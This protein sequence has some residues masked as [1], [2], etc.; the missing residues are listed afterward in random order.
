M[1]PVIRNEGNF[2]TVTVNGQVYSF[3]PLDDD[4]EYSENMIAAWTAWRDFVKEGW[5]SGIVPD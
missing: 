5:T 4:L 3:D 1:N 2:W